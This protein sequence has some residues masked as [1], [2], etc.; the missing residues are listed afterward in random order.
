MKRARVRHGGADHDVIVQDDGRLRAADGTMFTEVE[1]EWLPP[2]HGTILALGLNYADHASELALQA[3]KEPLIF[4]KAPSSLIGHRQASCR[5][6]SVEFMHFEGELAA[7]IGKTARNVR[8]GEAMDYVGGYTV[9]NDYA[10]RDYLENYY[11]PNL[12]VKSRD[13]LTP[14]GPWVVDAAEIGDPHALPVRTW[15]NG[16]LCQDGNT[17]D[18]VFDIPFLIE[19]LSAF[20]TLRP[21]DIISTG[22]PKG[23]INVMPGDVV[24][25]EVEGVGRLE[26]RIVSEAEYL[27]NQ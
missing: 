9:C 25:V 7:V 18:L 22:T 13:T 27:A 2:R 3:P 24:V 20:M 12:R 17:R 11:R 5:P 10:V 1:I 16:E 26:N 23:T 14:I 19:Y 15:V 4:I 6:D 21:G 8:R